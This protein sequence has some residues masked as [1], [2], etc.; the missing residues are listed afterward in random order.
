MLR[1]GFIDYLNTL[2]FNIENIKDIEVVRDVPSV[3]NRLIYEE[4][5]DIGIVSSAEYIDH[6]YRYFIIPN[7]SISSRKEVQSVLLLSNIP[8]EDID[9]VY[10]TRES[11]SSVLL[12]KVILE[13]FFNKAP[14]YKFFES[15]KNK[16]TI[17]VIGD[18]ALKLKREFLYSYDLAK[19][20]YEK[21]KLPFTFALWCVNR[22]SF[23]QKEEEVFKF[24]EK[25]R[26][27]VAE[28]FT[29]TKH[30]DEGILS[31]LK[32]LDYSLS[33]EHIR[34]LTLFSKYLY[35]MGLIK[36]IPD[37]RFTDGTIITRD[38]TKTVY[39][40]EYQE[41][42]H[43]TKAGAYTESLEKFVKPSGLAILLTE[44]KDVTILDVGFGL[45]Y[46]VTT[47]IKFA[48]SVV[49]KPKIEIIS[50][51]KDD[52]FLD[53]IE[54]IDY[55]NILKEERKFILSL[56]ETTVDIAGEKLRAFYNQE[57]TI[58]LTVIVE[59]G[60]KVLNLLKRD[61]KRFN[62][63]FYDPFSPKVNTEMWTVDIFK[64]IN[65]LMT[66]E[67]TFLTYSSAIP[68]KVGLIQAGFKLGYIEPVGRKS[69]SIV[70]TKKGN[71]VLIDEEE[72]IRI[73]NSKFAV[74]YKD[75]DFSLSSTEVWKRWER[76]I[77]QSPQKI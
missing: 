2:P 68:V 14:E 17:L 42:Y 64:V 48:K 37:F 8:L 24:Y 38:G 76:E 39:N 21:T 16:R 1:V 29:E 53:R 33:D 61:R 15:P 40:F 31:Y 62:I 56:K 52:R 26:R 13:K 59:E 47:A 5:I 23:I 3:L 74:P 36:S 7:L 71:I 12:L 20:W 70:A 34:S 22:S 4:K 35:Q 44:E 55:P 18:S 10:M 30:L 54:K 57:G 46:N 43:S 73:V 27:N 51:E 72:M 41:A 69:P 25:V 45:G 28:F 63:I 60:R 77:Q 67:A 66:D 19:I 11:K 50:I 65:H 9:T 6:Y 32:K 75:E 58:K 49:E